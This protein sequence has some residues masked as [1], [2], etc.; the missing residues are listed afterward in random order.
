MLR[1]CFHVTT[2]SNFARGFQKYSDRYS[3][4]AIPESTFADQFYL[5]FKHQLE[6][7]FS[8]ASKLLAK[9]SMPGDELLVLETQVLEQELFPNER[10]GLGQFIQSSSITVLRLY[11]AL[12]D[13]TVQGGYRLEVT[14]AEEAMA[15]SLA[16]LGDQMVSFAE[17][18]PR[19]FSVL[20]IARGCQAQCR[21]CFS[22]AS[23]SAVQEP[24]RL[25]PELVEEYAR[26]AAARGAER[27]V[28]TGGGE[29]GLIPHSQLLSYIRIGKRELG[30]VILITNGH[31]LGQLT[32]DN[33][34]SRIRDYADAGLDVLAVSRHHDDDDANSRIMNLRIDSAAIA[35]S[36]QLSHSAQKG[37][38]MRF[39]CVL[40]SQGISC[41]E[42]IAD[43]LTW[44]SSL[45]V[46]EV[47]FKELYVSTSTESVFHTY[48]ANQWSRE[49]R[50]PL[51]IVVR[52]AE[53]YNFTEISRLPWGSPIFSGEWLGRPMMV[54]AYT[55][56][57]LYWERTHGVA[58]SW[59]Q[60]A[61][62]ECLAS[63]EDRA[64]V[65]SLEKVFA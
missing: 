62:G 54:A 50:V 35:R 55:E 18:R 39:I 13:T 48:P 41:G 53:S 25:R 27:F 11:L 43:Y 36:W 7:G 46:E 22:E 61:D 59:N 40:Q 44:A 16:L 9:L 12:S 51:S 19:T 33:R 23:V 21:F 24:A 4:A 56:P 20:P 30:K 14:T 8:K 17:L 42:E 52:F 37:L 58:R 47:C 31:H 64:S 10:T 5:L 65:V 1:T 34:Q 3:K 49:H 45:N 15:R 29:P 38:R 6:I 26:A 63:L 57:S 60:M 28:I 32:E 2:L